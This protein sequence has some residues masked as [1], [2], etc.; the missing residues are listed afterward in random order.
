MAAPATEA[1]VVETPVTEAP[2]SETP[3]C[4]DTPAPM[5]TGRVG[6][7][8]SWAECVQA[9]ADKGFQRAR[10]AKHPQSQS[11]RCEPR[12]PLPFPLQDSERRLTSI[13]QLYEHVAEQ[14][15]THHNVAG[16]GIMHFH[17]E[18]LP[19]KARCLGNQ[20]TCMIVE[21][22]LTSSAQGLSSLS[23]II[24]QEAAALLPPLK[25]YVP[26]IAFED[27]RDVRVVDRA[28]TLRVA[29]WLHQLDM[30]V[31]GEGMASETLEA[32]RH[33]QGPCWSHS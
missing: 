30:A 31:E 10:P 14:P 8:Q 25:N 27:T 9:G 16:R 7:G 6:N 23:P 11:R 13:S 28:K 32:S 21:Y 15:V 33:Q 22:H 12:P 18:M 29:V 19:Q 3:A 26:S 1:P 4:S 17:L 24:P 5:E 20:V 2:V